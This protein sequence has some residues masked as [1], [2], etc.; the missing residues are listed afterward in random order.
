MSRSGILT[1]EQ[2]Y[3]DAYERGIRR[4]APRVPFAVS[5]KVGG[6][7]GPALRAHAVDGSGEPLTGEA[8]IAWIEREAEAFRNATADRGQFFAGWSPF[9]FT[10]WLNERAGEPATARAPIGTFRRSGPGELPANPRP[11][12]GTWRRE[13]NW[14]APSSANQGPGTYRPGGMPR[15]LQKAPGKK[16]GE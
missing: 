13:G 3:R 16:I 9:G 6:I 8:V 10:R 2:K 12:V 7:L 1:A 11:D 4:A 14:D 15:I 5:G